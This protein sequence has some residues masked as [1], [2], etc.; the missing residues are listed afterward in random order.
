MRPDFPIDWIK[1]SRVD[2]DHD[3]SRDDLGDRTRSDD[4]FA[5]GLFEEKCF[6]LAHVGK[7][8]VR[9]LG[10]VVVGESCG[11]TSFL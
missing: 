6:L 2:L 9:G 3:V 11:R 7:N 8:L 5:F 4:E 10:G 1:R